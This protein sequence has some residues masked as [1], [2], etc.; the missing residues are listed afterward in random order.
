MAFIRRPNEQQNTQ[1][2][3]QMYSEGG[4]GVLGQQVYS[5]GTGPQQK[6]KA[7]ASPSSWYNV[8]DFLGANQAAIPKYQE[9][10]NQK[11]QD[12]IGSDAVKTQEAVGNISAVERP[13]AQQFDANKAWT[14]T[15]E[16]LQG[17]LGQNYT[18]PDYTQWDVQANQNIQNL[19]PGSTASVVDFY[20]NTREQPRGQYTGGAR[21]MDQLIVGSDPDFVESFG[22]DV[23]GQ[24]ESQVVN[25]LTEALT[26]AEEAD[27]AKQA[28]LEQARA[29]WQTG[30]GGLL[31]EKQ[32]AVQSEYERQQKAYQDLQKQGVAPSLL[33]ALQKSGAKDWQSQFYQ[34]QSLKDY[35]SNPDLAKKYGS[36]QGMTG[37]MQTAA[38]Q[39]LGDQGI[40]QFNLIESLLGAEDPYEQ[41]AGQA[42]TA[43]KYTVNAQDAL[44]KYE[45]DNAMREQAKLQSLIGSRQGEYAKAQES[46][47]QAKEGWNYYQ[48]QLSDYDRKAGMYKE[49]MA[50]LGAELKG[51]RPGS[52]G[53]SE[54]Q[55]ALSQVSRNYQKEY[56]NWRN[57]KNSMSDYQTPYL[58][59]EK[60]LKN[61]GSY[62]NAY[63]NRSSELEKYL[64]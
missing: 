44:R 59:S 64:K 19:V 26:A 34:G 36:L 58:E 51:M 49:Q 15:Q 52:E 18:A 3:N 41:I 12:I 14:G 11:A 29:N 47:K 46:A 20:G 25:P 24:Y 42:Y 2:Q 54:K 8:Q 30:L 32:A 57:F 9:S 40:S 10:I 22:G 4:A 50:R 21:R 63:Q 13:E 35:F 5:G 45:Q 28:E 1:T 16:F 53:Y 61:I 37:N 27:L 33:A 7:Q 56:E 39:Y 62:L 55:Q 6:T 38:Q 17:G 31:G 23:K 48:N 60:A 43:P